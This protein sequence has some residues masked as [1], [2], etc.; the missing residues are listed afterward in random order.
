MTADQPFRRHQHVAS[1]IRVCQRSL[2]DIAVEQQDIE[3]LR[4]FRVW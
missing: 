1:V 3:D 4:Q 2:N